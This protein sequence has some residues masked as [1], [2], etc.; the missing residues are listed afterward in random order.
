MPLTEDLAV[1]NPHRLLVQALVAE[2]RVSLQAIERFDTE[3][4]TLAQTLP[5][6]SLFRVLPSAG[7]SLPA[8]PLAA[9][10]HRGPRRTA[11]W[12][13]TCQVCCMRLSSES[14]VDDDH[15]A[16]QKARHR[17]FCQRHGTCS[18]KSRARS[19]M[20]RPNWETAACG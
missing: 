16:W 11:S 17:A 4:T 14:G 18:A 13:L 15:G 5:D 6:Y 9:D 7:A 1:T 20:S 12:P 10:R 3:T 19:T 8:R 2:L